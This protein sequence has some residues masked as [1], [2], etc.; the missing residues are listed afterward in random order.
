[1]KFLVSAIKLLCPSLLAIF[2][3][4]SV[5]P[6]NSNALNLLVL[7]DVHLQLNSTTVYARPG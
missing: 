2:L 7:A 1:M 5:L 3:S 6:N 4:L